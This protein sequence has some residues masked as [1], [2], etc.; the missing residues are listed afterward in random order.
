M[1]SLKIEGNTRL[2][3]VLAAAFLSS[4]N[5]LVLMS[6]GKKVNL[7]DQYAIRFNA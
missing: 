5:P 2:G 6:T 7:T 4:G 3:E 1:H